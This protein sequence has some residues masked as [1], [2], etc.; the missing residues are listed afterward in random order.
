MSQIVVE[1]GDRFLVV[2]ICAG[3]GA[4]ELSSD[5]MCLC[6]D[7]DKRA[8]YA[9]VLQMHKSIR[10]RCVFSIFDYS[11][12][13]TDLLI[14]LKSKIGLDI[15]ILVQHPSPSKDTQS[16]KNLALAGNSIL[17]AMLQ[18]LVT[19]VTFVYDR[20]PNRNTWDR[21]SLKK[22]F[23]EKVDSVSQARFLIS[24]E[25]IISNKV[26]RFVNHPIFGKTE[27]YG[28]AMMRKCDEYEF[29]ISLLK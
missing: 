17:C 3:T 15:R 14:S 18:G 21:L 1:N 9:G 4:T 5:K 23:L 20:D 26:D 22:I 6:L 24:Q 2:S 10:R 11:Q 8:L 29:T 19:H 12:D 27:R 13:L 28:W 25:V 16:R 7:T